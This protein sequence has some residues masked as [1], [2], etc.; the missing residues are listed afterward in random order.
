MS[1]TNFIFQALSVFE[2]STALPP[3]PSTPPMTAGHQVF[4]VYF[5]VFGRS[6]HPHAVMEVIAYSAGFQLYLFFRRRWKG[7]IVPLEKN[8]WV[9]VGAIFGALVGSKVLAWVESWPDYFRF[10]KL[11]HSLA[12]L[13][14]GKTIVGGLLGGWIGVEAAKKLLRIRFSTGDLYVFPLIVGMS[15]G[16]VG[17]F[18]TGLAD[19]TYGNHTTLPWGVDFGDGPRHP[20]QLYD[21]V[22]LSLLGIA[23][24][25]RMQKP[26]ENGRIFRLFM[27][28][29]CLYRFSAEFIKPV[30]RRYLGLSAIQCACLLGAAVSGYLLYRSSSPSKP[31]A[32]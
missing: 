7:P 11:T 19:H 2:G 20:T 17:C 3:D 22:F 12:M 31:P 32:V 21:I 30:Y 16:R 25:I 1:H 15:I 8:L 27:L 13:A 10:W 6:F 18:L 9:I 14:G 26:F 5:H 23:L 4:P 24:W 29:Y 28:S